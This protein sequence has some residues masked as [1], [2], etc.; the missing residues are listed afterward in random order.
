MAS[1]RV[2]VCSSA[3]P[4]LVNRGCTFPPFCKQRQWSHY[5]TFRGSFN[6][7]N[8]LFFNLLFL[9]QVSACMFTLLRVRFLSISVL[10]SLTFYKG[11]SFRKLN[12]DNR[13][14]DAEQRKEVNKK[15]FIIVRVQQSIS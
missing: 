8:L 2:L 7:F 11:K 10:D 13:L 5:A 9:F 14:R 15:Y 4:P 1:V 12:V 6:C 3:R